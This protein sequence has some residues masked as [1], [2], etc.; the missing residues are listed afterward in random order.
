MQK[1]IIIQNPLPLFVLGLGS[2]LHTITLL[3]I[4][5][6]GYTERPA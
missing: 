5:L 1:K 4:A 6:P 2:E 3:V